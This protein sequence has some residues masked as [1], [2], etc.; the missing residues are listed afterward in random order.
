M[1]SDSIFAKL[2]IANN[3]KYN[4]YRNKYN[5]IFIDFSKISR[6]C[7]SYAKYIGKIETT[8]IRDLKKEYPQIEVYEDD[9]AADILETIFEECNQERFVFKDFKK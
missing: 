5:V 7:D 2:R 1:D 4:E 9:S 8:L 3:S 6:S